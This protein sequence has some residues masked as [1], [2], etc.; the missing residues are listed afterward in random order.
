SEPDADHLLRQGAPGR[1]LQRHLV[2]VAEP[3]RRHRAERQ[4]L[5]VRRCKDF[6]RRRPRAPVLFLGGGQRPGHA[7]AV[8]ISRLY[9]SHFWR[10]PALNGIVV[11]LPISRRL[12]RQANMSSR[13]HRTI[14]GMPRGITRALMLAAI[15]AWG[16][17]LPSTAL[18][19]SDD[20]DPEMQV[21]HLQEQLRTL[22]GQNEE[23]QHQNQLLQQRL[24]ALQGGAPAA[25]AGQP[26]PVQPGVATLPPPQ[27]GPNPGYRQPQYQPGYQQGYNQPPAAPAPLVEPAGGRRGDAFDPSQNPNAP[28]APRA[29]GGGQLPVEAPVG[30]PGGRAAG[31]PLNIES[32]NQINGGAPPPPPQAPGAGTR[33]TTLPPSASPKDEFD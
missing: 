7:R 19:Q 33:L 14:S 24:N 13:F 3:P 5:N 18:A 25:P 8:D 11:S 32:N 22:T 6:H 10:T 12:R 9:Q 2:L 21:Q 28:G 17:Q 30:A 26:A 23:L 20:G 27:P 16:A 15:V 1:G 29:L 4:L 31:E